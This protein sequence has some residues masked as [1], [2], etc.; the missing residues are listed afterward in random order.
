MESEDPIVADARVALASI[1]VGDATFRISDPAG[2][3][4]ADAPPDAQTDASTNASTNALTD[5]PPDALTDAPTNALTN[6]LTDAPSD[7]LTESIRRLGLL[8]PPLIGPPDPAAQQ[9]T[10]PGDGAGLYRI[11]SGFRRIAAC[12]RLGMDVIPARLHRGTD[13]DRALAAV[14]DNA[15]CRPLSL[16]ESSRALR[17]LERFAPDPKAL[18][19]LAAA[20]GLPGSAEWIRKTRP[21]CDLPEPIRRGV[22]D[23]AIPLAMALSLARLD[24]ADGSTLARL[25]RDLRP[26]LNKQRE[27]LLMAREIAL[28]DGIALTAVLNA[29]E[30]TA[31]IEDPGRDRNQRAEALRALLRARRYPALSAAEAAFER[32]RRRL[33]LPPEIRLAPPPAFESG[34]FTFQL[35]FSTP[36]ELARHIETLRE[37]SRADALI[38]ILG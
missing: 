31:A 23:G 26:G 21:L 4:A 1:D 7:A 36:A 14:A 24:P 37:L 3:E 15:L 19:A 12:V 30:M 20:A 9:A 25:F 35:E 33:S 27:I 22:A 2:P 6:A 17:L 11:I 13:L 8:Q 38:R 18:P 10:P 16:I 28:R 34:R 29:P 32:D 5:A